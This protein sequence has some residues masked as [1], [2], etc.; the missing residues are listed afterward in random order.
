MLPHVL[1]GD[2]IVKL[3]LDLQ[4]GELLLQLFPP[5]H[6]VFVG[7]PRPVEIGQAIQDGL[8]VLL[9]QT[10]LVGEVVV[11]VGQEVLQDEDVSDP[12]AVVV[13]VDQLGHGQPKEAL[14]FLV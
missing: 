9:V 7:Q 12:S 13:T 5:A 14:A 8:H 2:E 10:L 6:E 1:V 4:L 3:E 11:V